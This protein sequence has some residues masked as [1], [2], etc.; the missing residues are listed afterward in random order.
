MPG[1]PETATEG[2]VYLL[3]H[4]SGVY[5]IGI[6]LEPRSR[7]KQLKVGSSNALISTCFIKN[8]GA[9][10]K[11][12]Q[13]RYAAKRLPQSEYFALNEKDIEDIISFLKNG[14]LAI[15]LRSITTTLAASAFF[16]VLFCIGAII[17]K[18]DW[19]HQAA[20]DSGEKKIIQ[21]KA[22]I[23]GRGRE[24][25]YGRKTLYDSQLP[26]LLEITEVNIKSRDVSG[27]GINSHHWDAFYKITNKSDHRVRRILKA[28]TAKRQ[29]LH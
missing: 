7:F 29:L 12:L 22:S 5:K 17:S 4:S 9:I 13:A 27:L 28:S 6:T 16:L 11:Q 19:Q 14:E 15:P 24:V 2:W 20:I 25:V 21:K 1:R 26:P 10:E 18:D 8:P 3:R 23:N